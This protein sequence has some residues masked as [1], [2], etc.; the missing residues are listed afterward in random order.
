MFWACIHT[1]THTR[2]H[3]HAHTNTYTHYEKACR[4]SKCDAAKAYSYKLLVFVR[5]RAKKISRLE[6]KA[7]PVTYIKE[8]FTQYT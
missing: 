6:H 8:H 3:I 5:L 7:L 2:T 4:S 1:H